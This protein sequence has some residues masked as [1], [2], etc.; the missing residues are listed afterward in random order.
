MIRLEYGLFSVPSVILLSL[1]TSSGVMLLPCFCFALSSSSV[2]GSRMRS[3]SAE[4]LSVFTSPG[5]ALRW[6]HLNGK[7]FRRE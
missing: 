4:A 2:I 3:L 1:S 6:K 7:R 5:M